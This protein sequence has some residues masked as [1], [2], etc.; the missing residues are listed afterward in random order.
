MMMIT[1]L[2]VRS[3]TTGIVTH[4]I[5]RAEDCWQQRNDRPCNNTKSAFVDHRSVFVWIVLSWRYDDILD[6]TH[7]FDH[8]PPLYS[9]LRQIKYQ[10]I[11]ERKQERRCLLLSTSLLSTRYSN[12]LLTS[13]LSIKSI[14]MTL[15]RGKG[16]T[17]TNTHY[18]C[19]KHWAVYLCQIRWSYTWVMEKEQKA[20]A[21]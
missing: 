8:S 14:S 6:S 16:I 2:I 20:I 7:L 11:N 13:R 15:R 18:T 17:R 1:W 9:H 21:S 4:D 19:D 10:T 5:G 12:W 3:P